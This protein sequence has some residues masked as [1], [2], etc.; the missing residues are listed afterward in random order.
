MM[1]I[2]GNK[3]TELYEIQGYGHMM[4]YPAIPILLRKIK[5]ICNQND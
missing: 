2:S 3:K 5:E 4:V 1:K